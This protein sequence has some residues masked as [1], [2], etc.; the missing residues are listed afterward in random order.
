MRVGAVPVHPRVR[1][2]S[3]KVAKGAGGMVVWAPDREL[4]CRGVVYCAKYAGDSVREGVL[5]TT[6]I[7]FE[8]DAVWI[9]HRDQEDGVRK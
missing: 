7:D 2:R 3:L 6:G 9:L 8:C 1:R 5:E 4:K